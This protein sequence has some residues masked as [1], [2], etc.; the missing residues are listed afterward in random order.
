M[1]NRVKNFLRNL[2]HKYRFVVYN[3]TTFEVKSSFFLSRMNVIL[4]FCFIVLISVL[5]SS[6]LIVYSPLKFYIPGYGD[7]GLRKELR[8]ARNEADDL[9]SQMKQ[10]D[11]WAESIKQ[12]LSGKIPAS[13]IYKVNS[14]IED[15]TEKK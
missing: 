15:T 11:A 5:L 6:M 3:E 14:I 13:K 8:D 10:N 9:K 2:R 7:I 4:G 12:V 1:T